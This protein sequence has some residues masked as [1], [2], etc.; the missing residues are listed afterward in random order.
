MHPGVQEPPEQD[1]SVAITSRQ[2]FG[3]E[4]LFFPSLLIVSAFTIQLKYYLLRKAFLVFL[5]EM[6]HTV[7]DAF[8]EI[9]FTVFWE[10][11]YHYGIVFLYLWVCLYWGSAECIVV[12]RQSAWIEDLHL[13]QA[14]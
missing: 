5:D 2:I 10:I 4:G 3:L 11:E 14:M 12:K 13:S 1:G 6:N 7:L 8:M 9:S